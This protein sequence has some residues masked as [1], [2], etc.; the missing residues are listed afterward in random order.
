[1]KPSTAG[2]FQSRVKK[3]E[4]GFALSYDVNYYVIIGCCKKHILFF[5]LFH[6]KWFDYTGAILNIAYSF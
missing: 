5:V 2:S 1:M 6:V 3:C 4:Q